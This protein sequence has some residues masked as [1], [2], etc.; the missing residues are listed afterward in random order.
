MARAQLRR[1]PCDLRRD[2]L[3]P[4]PGLSEERSDDPDRRRPLTVRTHEDFRE[5]ACGEH[6]LV[7]AETLE[8]GNGLVMHGVA[9]IEE[10]DHDARI[11][12]YRQSARSFFRYP[13][14][15]RTVPA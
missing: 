8:R 9:G 14:G 2:R 7:I 5:G 6:D 3:D 12:D 10:R 1:S 4:D 13:F 15:N 11:D